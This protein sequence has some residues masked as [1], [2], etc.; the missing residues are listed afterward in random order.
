M[1]M[2]S[3]DHEK[4]SPVAN[5]GTRAAATQVAAKHQI[6]HEAKQP[7]GAIGDD[8]LLAGKTDQVAVG[9]DERG[10]PSAQQA[11]LGRADDAGQQ[12]PHGNDQRHLQQ[13]EGEVDDHGQDARTTRSVIS[14]PKTT[15]RYW[16]MVRN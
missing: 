14:A 9:L 11:R 5:V 13:L 1:A 2:R 8:R 10:S 7:R 16:R 3:A 6:G 15:L 12:G 4:R